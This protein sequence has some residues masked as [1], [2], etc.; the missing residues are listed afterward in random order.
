LCFH[1]RGKKDKEERVSRRLSH[2]GN[3]SYLIEENLLCAKHNNKLLYFILTM[4]M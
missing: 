2:S 3:K 4:T 1:I